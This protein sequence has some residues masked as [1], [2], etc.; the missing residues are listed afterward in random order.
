[1]NKPQSLIDAYKDAKQDYEDKKR[2][3]HPEYIKICQWLEKYG[4]EEK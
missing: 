4:K 3:E 2:T 1:M